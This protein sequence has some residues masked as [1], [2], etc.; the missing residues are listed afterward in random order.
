MKSYKNPDQINPDLLEYIHYDPGKPK[1]ALRWLTN[2]NC[3]TDG[4]VQKLLNTDFLC[5]NCTQIILHGMF[6]WNWQVIRS[7]GDAYIVLNARWQNF[8]MNMCTL[9]YIV[10]PSGFSCLFFFLLCFFLSQMF[11]SISQELEQIF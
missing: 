6:V 10:L 1:L 2:G 5:N 4:N 3:T 11:W 9:T 8:K 7:Y